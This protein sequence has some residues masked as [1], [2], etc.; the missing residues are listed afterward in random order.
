MLEA[1]FGKVLITPPLGTLTAQGIDSEAE[2]VLDDV[3]VRALALRDGGMSVCLLSVDVIGFGRKEI[4]QMR[5]AV[6]SA[7]MPTPARGSATDRVFCHATHSHESPSIR[8]E[9][10]ELLR[11]WD[12]PAHSEMWY[13]TFLAACGEAA[14]LAMTDLAPA[15]I[16]FGQAEIEGIASNRRCVIRDDGTPWMR[17]SRATD[18]HRALPRGPIDPFCRVVHFRRPGRSDGVLVNYACHPTAAGGDEVPLITGDFPGDALRRLETDDHLAGIYFT[19][20]G[21]DINPGKYTG[22]SKDPDDRLADVRKMGGIL[23]EGV[24]QAL[25]NARPAPG[26]LAWQT[27]AIFLPVPPDFPTLGE[28]ESE[29]R[30]AADAYVEQRRQG[31]KELGGGPLIWRLM[32]LLQAHR[33]IGRSFPTEIACLRLGT[34]AIPFLPGEC[35]H[36]I[37]LTLQDRLAAEFVIPV[38]YCDTTMN[39]IVTP[40]AF[41]EGGYGPSTTPLA[42][43]AA[44][45]LIEH[46]VALDR[47]VVASDSR[48]CHEGGRR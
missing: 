38:A 36:Q 44:E 8:T 45:V 25:A 29:F 37:G 26:C 4:K 1:G 30:N 33:M 43:N 14:R 42:R 31:K 40:E 46:V 9:F 34:V 23:A 32:R 10:S 13:R 18:Q 19:G 12:L 48:K 35:F 22:G 7:C 16:A 24:R 41:D 3:F 17:S 2:A 27:R 20:T 39:Y 6:A 15:E 28:L 21:G 11:P 47:K 5:S